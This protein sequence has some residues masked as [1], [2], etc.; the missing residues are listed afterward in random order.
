MWKLDS[1]MTSQPIRTM[2]TNDA[3][4]ADVLVIAISSLER[5][6]FDLFHWLDF[7]ATRKSNLP[8]PGLLIGLLGNEENKSRELSWTVN[9]LIHCAQRANRDFIWQWMGQGANADSDWLTENVGI[10]L[11]RKQSLRTQAVL[12][13]LNYV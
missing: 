13:E 2:I 4:N 11:A 1:L 6:A 3:A 8:V 9:Q 7:L 5:C 12:Q 10:L